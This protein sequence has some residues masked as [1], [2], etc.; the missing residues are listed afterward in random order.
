ML[1]L[2]YTFLMQQRARF[3]A[4]VFD[5]DGTLYPASALYLRCIDIFVRHPRVVEGFSFVRKALRTMQMR[6]D[7]APRNAEELHQLQASLLA[8]HTHIPLDEAHTLIEYTFYAMLPER[9]ASIRPFPGVRNA[10][11]T[12]RSKGFA[13]AA[14]SDL[15]P[16]EKIRALGLSDLL[17]NALC[18]EDFGVLKPHPRVFAA[19]V[20]KLGYEPSEILYVGNN[21]VYDIQGAKNAGLG[22]ARRGRPTALADFSFTKWEKL[23][24][25]V[26]NHRA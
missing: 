26:L 25:W 17:E 12:I 8:H 20:E 5:V 21:P 16:T 18:A 1:E 7:Y 24:E 11:E 4:V 19:L 10:I 9:F 13:V 15:P 22:A 3:R 23:A 14:L 2:L 6:S